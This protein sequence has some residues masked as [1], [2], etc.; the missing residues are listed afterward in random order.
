MRETRLLHKWGPDWSSQGNEPCSRQKH[1]RR[2]HSS[3]KAKG[4][5][6]WKSRF[7]GTHLLLQGH[8]SCSGLWKCFTRL[9]AASLMSS[10][11]STDRISK[12]K[13][14]NNQTQLKTQTKEWMLT[15]QRHRTHG[16]T[17]NYYREQDVSAWDMRYKQVGQLLCWRMLCVRERTASAQR[18]QH[19]PDTLGRRGQLWRRPCPP[20]SVLLSTRWH[21]MSDQNSFQAAIAHAFP[22]P[23][24]T[25]KP[26]N[27]ETPFPYLLK[28]TYQRWRGWPAL[29]PRSEIVRLM[30]L[31][32]QTSVDFTQCLLILS[33]IS[34]VRSAQCAEVTPWLGS[35][36]LVGVSGDLVVNHH[37]VYQTLGQQAG[38][39]LAQLQRAQAA[40]VLALKWDAWTALLEALLMLELRRCVCACVRMGRP[41]KI[42][43]ACSLVFV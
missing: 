22:Q 43:P 33:N 30:T 38:V 24:T 2:F 8:T 23:S 18:S 25:R 10:C 34:V 41:G 37:T 6:E 12:P 20:A 32:N 35:I 13:K 3:S 19:S 42:S 1:G 40:Q 29:L 36:S 9:F 5:N 4:L 31:L 26:A 28:T 11:T 16:W 39:L 21:Q 14:N 7:C 15:N 17:E 27:R